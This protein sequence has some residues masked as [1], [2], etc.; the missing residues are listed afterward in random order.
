MLVK[1]LPQTLIIDI[2][3]VTATTTTTTD[4]DIDLLIVW[5]VNS[6]GIMPS[7]VPSSRPPA[8][9]WMLNVQL[10]EQLRT[11]PD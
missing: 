4:P 9:S 1:P 3:I 6:D 2:S 10:L 8:A 11:T 5:Q 7:N